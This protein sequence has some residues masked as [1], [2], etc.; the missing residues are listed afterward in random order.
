[1][2]ELLKELG[3]DNINEFNKLVASADL[4]SPEKLDAFKLWKEKDGSKE[5]LLKLQ[6]TTPLSPFDSPFLDSSPIWDT[7]G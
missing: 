4:S 6:R 7:L 2:E 3:F 1:M 5:G